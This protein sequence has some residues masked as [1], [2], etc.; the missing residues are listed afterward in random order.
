MSRPNLELMLVILLGFAS[1]FAAHAGTAWNEAVSGDLS[2]NGLAPTALTVAAGSN[3]VVGTV[4]DAGFGVDRDYFKITVPPGAKL[5]SIVMLGNTFVSGSASFMGIQPG[6]Q[7]T[8][9]PTTGAGAS[10]LLGFTHYTN[11]EVG[12]DIL[13]LIAPPATYP[14]GLPSGTYT[15]WIQDTGGTVDYGFDFVIAPVNGAADAP[16]PLW[17]YGVLGSILIWLTWRQTA[18]PL[19]AR[20]ITRR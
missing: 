19:N 6:P 9:S 1:P 20:R 5:A 2:G 14:G 11:D 16:L 7:V 18:R 12:T 10:A 3:T 8:V 17:T 15:I 13:P 4:G